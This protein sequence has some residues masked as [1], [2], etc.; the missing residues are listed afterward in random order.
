MN[1]VF[2]SFLFNSFFV[3]ICFV[4]LTR[5]VNAEGTPA[6]S[7]MNAV[8]N[9]PT[10]ATLFANISN[11]GGAGLVIKKRGFNF[12]PK[13]NDN[14]YTSKVC[15]SGSFLTGNYSLITG[16]SCDG[17]PSATLKCATDYQ[18]Q[19]FV[20]NKDSS[21]TGIKH[22]FTTPECP[23]PTPTPTIT[24]TPTPV[25]DT[26]GTWGWSS[27]IGWIDF[28]DIKI[29]KNGGYLEGYGWSNNIGW[30]KFGGLSNFP[31]NGAKPTQAK[32]N[33][34]T[35]VITGWARACAGTVGGET[36][37]TGADCRSMDSR[38]DGWD[39][40]IELN[41]DKNSADRSHMDMKTGEVTG[42][43]W[44]SDVV[45]WIKFGSRPDSNRPFSGTCT[46]G[47]DGSG[48]V[49]FSANTVGGSGQFSYKWGNNDYSSNSTYTIPKSNKS[50]ETISLI[51]KDNNTA[52]TFT[53]ICPTINRKSDTITGNCTIN[54]VPYDKDKTA[55]FYVGDVVTI[56]LSGVWGGNGGPY[57]YKLNAGNGFEDF[58][59]PHSYTFAKSANTTI[60]VQARDAIGVVASDIKCANANIINRELSLKIGANGNLAS[61]NQYRTKLGNNFGLKWINTLPKYNSVYVD[62]SNNP[63]GYTC[64]NSLESPAKSNWTATWTTY[65]GVGDVSGMNTPTTGKFE[66][67]ITC[68]SNGGGTKKASVL[69]NVF[70]P[71]EKE[72]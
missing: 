28:R 4:S 16:G 6:V 61:Q 55:T 47:A 66:F 44:G 11:T 22:T 68:T 34:S 40:W 67:Q 1:K 53:P 35:G 45:G 37:T 69:L 33:V 52:E 24:P 54:G 29:N 50:F 65:D 43:A 42:F 3:L 56:A 49:I 38:T 32:L 36:P 17:V 2:S 51:I 14:T 59:S 12:G 71:E 41:D 60:Y 5:S 15:E 48:N 26:L 27:T 21:A 13:T 18:F 72:I 7:T 31:T 58:V 63:A 10:D 8:N 70:D 64:S 9:S 23:T 30:V 39:G 46:G 25:P 62:N 57:T 20:Q 19:A